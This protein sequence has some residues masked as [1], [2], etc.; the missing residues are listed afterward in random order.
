MYQFPPFPFRTYGF[1]TESFGYLR[2]EACL[3]LPGVLFI[4]RSPYWFTIG[5]QGIFS[6]T[7]WSS[8]IPTG[9]LV[10]RSTWVSPTPALSFKYRTFTFYGRAFHPIP[11]DFADAIS[12]IPRPPSCCHAGFGLMPFRSPLLRQSLLFSFPGGT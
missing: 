2:I 8:R 7:R 1:S 9:F 11:L 5:R 10:P 3:R 6:L 12:V 4:F